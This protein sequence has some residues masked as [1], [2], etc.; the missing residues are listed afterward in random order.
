[1][2]VHLGSAHTAFTGVGG[3]QL[4]RGVLGVQLAGPIGSQSDD[5][6]PYAIYFSQLFHL[7]TPVHAQVPVAPVEARHKAHSL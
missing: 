7:N 3:S 4:D 2:I 1:M 5:Q 6:E